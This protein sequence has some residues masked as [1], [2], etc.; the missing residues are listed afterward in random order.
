[1]SRKLLNDP[2]SLIWS[3]CGHQSNNSQLLCHLRQKFHRTG[4]IHNIY[5]KVIFRLN[6]L[7]FCCYAAVDVE[8]RRPNSSLLCMQASMLVSTTLFNNIPNIPTHFKVD[9]QQQHGWPRAYTYSQWLN[10]WVVRCTWRCRRWCSVHGRVFH[11][12]ILRILCT[13]TFT[14]LFFVSIKG[15]N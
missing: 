9:R 12:T 8:P 3:N 7:T 5:L 2:L 13:H 6:P 14:C 4:I 1:M 10:D 15:K 11:F